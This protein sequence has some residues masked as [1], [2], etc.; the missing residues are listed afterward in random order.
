MLEKYGLSRANDSTL[1]VIPNMC[2]TQWNQ[3]PNVHAVR[4]TER[5]ITLYRQKIVLL[6]LANSTRPDIAWISNVLSRFSV[7]PQPHHY[8]AVDQVFRYLKHSMHT[9]LYFHPVDTNI[10]IYTDADFAGDYDQGYSTT[11]VMVL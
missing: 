9:A 8:H 2:L 6:Y 7:D 4:A 10:T 5:E 11:G 3:D 1:S